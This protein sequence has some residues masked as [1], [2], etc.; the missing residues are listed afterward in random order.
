MGFCAH[1]NLSKI[2][3]YPPLSSGF[4][5]VDFIPSQ[6]FLQDGKRILEAFHLETP[7]ESFCLFN[8]T[9]TEGSQWSP[10]LYLG[11]YSIITQPLIAWEFWESLA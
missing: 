5:C 2:H 11:G 10:S 1:M 4:S 3:L 9:P 7:M 8:N 6:F